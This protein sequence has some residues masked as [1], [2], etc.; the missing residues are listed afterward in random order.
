M[1]DPLLWMLVAVLGGF[2]WFE[3]TGWH[4]AM[5]G[6]HLPTLEILAG[7]MILTQ[8]LEHSRFLDHVGQFLIRVAPHERVLARWLTLFTALL[9][10][11]L[12]NDIALFVVVPLTLALQRHGLPSWRR[13]VIMEA[14]A[15]NVGATLS[16]LGSP[17]NIFLWQTSG[18]SLGAFLSMMGAWVVWLVIGLALLVEHAFVRRPLARQDS[19]PPVMVNRSLFRLS[20]LLYLPFLIAAESG[21]PGW[22]LATTTPLALLHRPLLNRID[23]GLLAIFTLFFIDIGWLRT[24]FDAYR[25]P[26]LGAQPTPMAWLMWGVGLSQGI[27]NVPATLYLERS[28]SNFRALAY[29]VNAGG[30]GWVIGSMANLIA[31]RLARDRP[32]WREFHRFSVPFL[33]YALCTAI[34]VLQGDKLL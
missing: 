28:D 27:S 24:I 25:L 1:Q 22:A 9:A 12:T 15:A 34:L 4:G 33:G 21:H 3:P 29:G 10:T 26:G 5:H 17:Q 16:P 8:G 32:I 31:L 6:I 20:A 19:A 18:V 14:L 7:L 23:W 2:V 11:V 13:L 30:F